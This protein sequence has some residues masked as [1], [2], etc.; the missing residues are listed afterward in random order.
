MEKNKLVCETPEPLL[1]GKPFYL[2][3]TPYKA[4]PKTHKEVDL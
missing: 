3:S 4:T 1:R 2:C